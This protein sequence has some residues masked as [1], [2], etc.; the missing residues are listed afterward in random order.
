MG[1]Y[2]RHGRNGDMVREGRRGRE[3]ERERERESKVKFG[4]I[5]SWSLEH[6]YFEYK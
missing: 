4:M 3:R 2:G 6:L 5:L 1:A